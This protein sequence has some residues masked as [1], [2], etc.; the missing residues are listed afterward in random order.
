MITA[1]SLSLLCAPVQG[2]LKNGLELIVSPAKTS[3]VAVVGLV[4]KG[5]ADLD[6]RAHGKTHLAYALQFGGGGKDQRERIKTLAESGADFGFSVHSDHVRY[7]IAG[8]AD[9]W[10]RMVELLAAVTKRLD[11]VD[12]ETFERQRMRMVDTI[13]EGR[14]SPP[15]HAQ[16]QLPGLV[17]GSNHPYGH[18]Q[19]GS[20]WTLATLSS[21]AIQKH[22]KAA[23]CPG[24]AALIAVGPIELQALKKR[25]KAR[26]SRWRRCRKKP[27]TEIAVKERPRRVVPI[28]HEPNRA[29]TLVLAALASPV[30]DP[31]DLRAIEL[32]GHTLGGSF[33]SRMQSRLREK[34]GYTYGA[35]TW[36][37]V[38]RGAAMLNVRTAL[39]PKRTKE[40]LTELLATIEDL[41]KRPPT[42]EEVLRFTKA[43][44]TKR[45]LRS[46][47][48]KLIQAA[49]RFAAGLFLQAT[50]VAPSA[51]RLAELSQ[52]YVRPDR[53]Q[54]VLIG[55]ANSLQ[56]TVRE[57]GLGTPRLL[58]RRQ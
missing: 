23:V 18:T 46:P 55:D 56:K 28:I 24:N 53:L 58:S 9:Q 19:Y 41:K 35:Q 51:D 37:R 16:T 42:Q 17:F 44:E 36:L 20:R 30:R 21:G 13:F 49:V 27:A 11:K 39:D 5:G 14:R 26:F 57:A 45:S 34:G 3:Q 1:L 52:R 43:K 4:I 50:E 32:L 38:Q 10:P 15:Y 6:L 48:E 2:Q 7:Y 40:G 33:S 29:Q 8:L 22:L 31:E 12:A 47:N 54:L 25:A